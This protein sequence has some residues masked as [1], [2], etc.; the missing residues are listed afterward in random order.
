ME[1]KKQKSTAKEIN[2]IQEIV[3]TIRNDPK[4]MKQAQK[5]IVNCS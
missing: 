2:E 1:S 4:A 5:L 3:I